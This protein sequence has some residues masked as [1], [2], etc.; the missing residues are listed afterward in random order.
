[1]IIE[2][3]DWVHHSVEDQSAGACYNH[4]CL[5]VC[6]YTSNCAPNY[7]SLCPPLAMCT[8]LAHSR[9]R[10]LFHISST[11]NLLRRRSPR[12]HTVCHGRP[13]CVSSAVH[14]SRDFRSRGTTRVEGGPRV[15]VKCRIRD[16]ENDGKEGGDPRGRKS[17]V[18]WLAR[19]GSPSAAR[20]SHMYM[21]DMQ[22]ITRV[23]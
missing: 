1:M 18:S 21:C 22:T 13:R 15:D 9:I 2:K 7:P 11:S 10:V 8:P 20:V 5:R 3:P 12:R 16:F 14:V 19:T 6:R 23:K 17:G 4:S